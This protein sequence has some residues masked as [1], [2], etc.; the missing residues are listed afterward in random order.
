MDAQKNLY[1]EEAYELLATLEDALIELEQHPEDLSIVGR[2][3]RAMHTLKGSG[4]MFGFDDIAAFT[5]T[6]ETVYDLIRDGNLKISQDL[7]SLTLS[8]CD[9]I[10][11]MLD[12]SQGLAVA[13][14]EKT[15]ELAQ[16]F[17]GYLPREEEPLDEGAAG[18]CSPETREEAPRPLTTF[19]IRFRP[20]RDLFANGTNPIPLLNELKDLGESAIVCHMDDLPDLKAMDPEA[21]YTSWDII[22]TTLSDINTIR[23]VFIFVEDSSEISIE[24]VDTLTPKDNDA[25]YK[26]MGEILLERGSVQKDDLDKALKTQKRLGE[27]LVEAG[28]VDKSEIRSALAEQEQVRTL[29]KKR[30]AAEETSSIRVPAAR[31][32]AL[33][34]LV[35]ELVTVQARLTQF[36][37]RKS[38]PDL[39]GIAEEVERLSAELRDISMGIRMLPIGTTF[40]KFKRL[41]RDLTMS[42]GKDINFEMEGEETELDKTVIDKLSDPLVHLIR[43]SIDHGI[44]SPDARVAAG[45]PSQGMIK[46]SARHSGAHVLIS[47]ADDG[48]GLDV[49]AIR[50]KA[51]EKG[52]IPHEA[53]LSEYE[54]HELI[55]APG[56]STASIVT[57]VSGRGVGMDVVRSSI[58]GL[59][60]TVEVRS[61]RGKGTTI[62]LK[63]PLTLAI[64][65]GLLVNIANESFV[66]PL[67][68]VVECVELTD[69]ERRHAHGRNLIKVREEI[70][71]Y[72]PL[73]EVFGIN[74]G[75]PSIDQ[76]VITELGDKRVGFVV[77]KVIGQHQTVI[78]TMGSFLR[79]IEGISGATI[80]GDGAVAL[81]LDVYKLMQHVELMELNKYCGNK[82]AVLMD[83]LSGSA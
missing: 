61:A 36:S 53:A 21:C 1:R 5:H 56:F 13:S 16:A 42:L 77:D 65:D 35:G 2:V 28:T 63:L 15:R 47:I 72:I 67:G 6:I 60:G 24:P 37:A 29:R 45:K 69:A 33:V 23:D 66:I 32:D 51:V 54:I 14:E 12:A 30:A 64:I 27:V 73:R 4:A 83:D 82:Q 43:N 11:A 71:P 26:K 55:F 22:L 52:I 8:S 31:L 9:Q 3:F 49:D 57:S 76:V 78:K 7:I 58:E 19:R 39:L 10:K 50:A 40:A 62:T 18:P 80:L 17:K 75:T 38:D 70:I 34:N 41:V 25:E 81:I 48:N 59:N 68:A 44:E 46:L 74:G 20:H 79:D